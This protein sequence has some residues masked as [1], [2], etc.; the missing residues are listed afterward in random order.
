MPTSLGLVLLDSRY[1]VVYANH[2]ALSALA[3]LS[4]RNSHCANA[5]VMQNLQALILRFGNDRKI[6]AQF[7]YA[8]R[9]WRSIRFTLP[10]GTKREQ[11]RAL[12]VGAG[13]ASESH[14]ATF[15]KMFKLTTREAEA[16]ELFMKGLSVKETAARMKISSSTAKAFLRFVTMKMGVSGR[17]E[18]MSNILNYMCAASLT[19]PFRTDLP[20]KNRT[21][22]KD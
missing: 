13:S 19:C 3:P 14:A 1:Q 16:L 11:M 4:A 22:P 6:P 8:G 2:E 21:S 7:N 12:I 17:A 5:S 20:I 9:T 10:I 15:A 18:M